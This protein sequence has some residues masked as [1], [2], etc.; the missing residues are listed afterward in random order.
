M[1][2]R[3]LFLGVDCGLGG[4]IALIDHDGQLLIVEDMPVVARGTKAKLE[5]DGANLAFLLRPYASDI[6]VAAIERPTAM[7]GQGVSSSFNFGYSVGALVGVVQALA[8]PVLLPS[9]STWKRSMQLP[10]DKDVV[11]GEAI[12]KWPAHADLFRRKRDDGRAESAFLAEFARR[13]A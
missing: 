9:P 5:V 8:I 7:S 12:R 6:K 4:G 3:Q 2:R 1:S 11:R 13:S 10:A